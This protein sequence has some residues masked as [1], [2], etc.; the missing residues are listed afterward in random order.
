MSLA[1]PL[2]CWRYRPVPSFW[3]FDIVA[4]T[5]ITTC[6]SLDGNH[7]RGDGILTFERSSRDRIR[8]VPRKICLHVIV[9]NDLKSRSGA[10]LTCIEMAL[11]VTTK[12]KS[13]VACCTDVHFTRFISSRFPRLHCSTVANMKSSRIVGSKNASV[14][15]S[16][17]GSRSRKTLF[18]VSG[19]RASPSTVEGVGRE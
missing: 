5:Y 12:C 8:T 10:C 17:G 11:Q 13:F 6:L 15:H 19:R 16:H 4:C 9:E 14:S 18:D 7:L 2:C 3:A 1:S